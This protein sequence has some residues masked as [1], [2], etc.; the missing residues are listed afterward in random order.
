MLLERPFSSLPSE[1][2]E[3]GFAGAIMRFYRRSYVVDYISLACLTALWIMVIDKQAAA[4]TGLS[5][6]NRR[7]QIQIFVTPFHQLFS[8]DDRSL[9]YPMSEEERV[10]LGNKPGPFFFQ[11]A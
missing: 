6:T 10:S 8:L 5:F 1:S 2:N 7:L 3:D 9:R 11:T 4:S